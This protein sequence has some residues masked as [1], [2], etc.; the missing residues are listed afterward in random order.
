MHE[1]ERQITKGKG[2]IHT[3]IQNFVMHGEHQVQAAHLLC[4]RCT[5]YCRGKSEGSL[6]LELLKSFCIEWEASSISRDNKV[7]SVV[8]P[9]WEHQPRPGRSD[10]LQP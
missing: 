9:T 2:G 10:R 6:H 8:M 5:L 7:Q 1:M 3:C 4:M